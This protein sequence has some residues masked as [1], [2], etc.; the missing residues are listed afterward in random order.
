MKTFRIKAKAKDDLKGIAAF[1][2]MRWGKQQRNKYLYQFNDTF[3]QL[4]VNPELGRKCDFI[5]SG[6]RKFPLLSHVIYYRIGENE[7]V[8]IIR[9][10]HK[11]MDVSSSRF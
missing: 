11:R 4:A 6:Y 10:L 9:I 7:S 1:T 2:Q 8:E 3:Q 5:R